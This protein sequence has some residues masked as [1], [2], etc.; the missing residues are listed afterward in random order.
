MKRSEYYEEQQ[1]RPELRDILLDVQSRKHQGCEAELRILDIGCGNGG[2]VRTLRQSL[3]RSIFEG[4]EVDD[5]AYQTALPLFDRLF[6]GT[7]EDYMTRE[8]TPGLY[9]FIFLADILEHLVDPWTILKDLKRGLKPDGHIIMSIPNV[10]NY[11]VIY[12]LLQGR[13]EYQPAGGLLDASHLR[14]FTLTDARNM[15][16]KAGYQI[17]SL[18]AALNPDHEFID[19]MSAF[20]ATLGGN[21]ETFREEAQTFQYFFLISPA[22]S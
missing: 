15:I 19:R 6:H 22:S 2:L 21:A 11:R 16:L 13:W 18:R 4:V 5:Y 20:V 3:C 8:L 17:D 9:D 7:V 10:G 12:G 14:F 1:T